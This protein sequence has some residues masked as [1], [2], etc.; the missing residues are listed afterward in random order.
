MKYKPTLGAD[1]H[2]KVLRIPYEGDI[3]VVTLQIWDTGGQ[4]KI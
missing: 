4:E 3:K 2:R 1:M